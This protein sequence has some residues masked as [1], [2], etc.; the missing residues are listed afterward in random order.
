[1]A[2]QP[3][4]SQSQKFFP[5]G[6][7]GSI[8][9]HFWSS[10]WGILLVYSDCSANHPQ[11]TG[12][13]STSK[14]FLTP[15][16]NIAE[17]ASPGLAPAHPSSWTTLF[18]TCASGMVDFFVSQ[19]FHLISHFQSLVYVIFAEGY[20]PSPTTLPSHYL[21][22]IL[23][24]FHKETLSNIHPVSYTLTSTFRVISKPGWS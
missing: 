14:N 24:P 5:Q 19:N 9:R 4:G 7:F 3:S 10:H 6:A 8:W 15:N 12:Q 13:N 23:S 1:M 20:T 18:L 11:G 17:V 21:N 16:V 2:Q 22:V